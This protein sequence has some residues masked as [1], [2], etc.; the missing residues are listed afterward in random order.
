MVIKDY[1]T[2]QSSLN[3]TYNMHIL[4]TG[5]TW[6]LYLKENILIMNKLTDAGVIVY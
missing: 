6:Y 2:L 5:I 1:D 4:R 3:K